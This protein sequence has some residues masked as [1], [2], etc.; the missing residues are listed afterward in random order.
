[1]GEILEI[2]TNLEISM[3]CQYQIQEES[4]DYIF[5]F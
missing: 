5:A 2:S 4:A 3:N 1:M